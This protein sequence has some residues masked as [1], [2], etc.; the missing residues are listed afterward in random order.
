MKRLFLYIYIMFRNFQLPTKSREILVSYS[1]F[2][3]ALLIFILPDFDVID[4]VGV[5]LFYLTFLNVIYLTYCLYNFDNSIKSLFLNKI[6]LS[7]VFFLIIS[8]ISFFWSLNLTESFVKFS[9]WFN[10]YILFFLSS[11][12]LRNISIYTL[13]YFVTFFLV[14]HLLIIFIDY[15]EIISNTTFSFQYANF[16]RG[17]ASNKNIS[18]ALII[19]CLPFSYISAIR[20]KNLFYSIFIFFIS[21]CSFYFIFTLSA[22][23]VFV[24]IAVSCFFIFFFL[25]I[26]FFKMKKTRFSH[27]VKPIIFLFYLPLIL[28]YIFFNSSSGIDVILL[29]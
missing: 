20:L 3:L 24:T 9:Y 18:S 15:Y 21:F 13:G 22:R 23:S 16:L 27:L 10:V 7:F 6:N 29:L 8:L 26:S 14:A 17:L 1:F 2:A 25:L 5:Q 19:F 12:F 4:K 11:F 28:S